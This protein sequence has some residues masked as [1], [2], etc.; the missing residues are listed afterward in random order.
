MV[1]A[2][3]K[4]VERQGGLNRRRWMSFDIVNDGLGLLF[5]LFV[6]VGACYASPRRHWRRSRR[7]TSKKEGGGGRK[8]GLGSDGL[9]G[10]G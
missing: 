4:K 3:E 5:T 2:S 8:L 1:T 9:L 10:L 7:G 6:V